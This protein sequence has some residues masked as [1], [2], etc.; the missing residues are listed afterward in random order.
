MLASRLG[1]PGPNPY[2]TWK[3]FG[4]IKELQKSLSV[5]WVDFLII[6]S[7]PGP[8]WQ[9]FGY[10]KYLGAQEKFF[11]GLGGGGGRSNYSISSWPWL[12]YI[13]SMLFKYSR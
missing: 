4:Y 8:G 6:V 9:R 2:P 10:I 11:G 7:T 12:V 5:G 13:W 3:R 1:Q